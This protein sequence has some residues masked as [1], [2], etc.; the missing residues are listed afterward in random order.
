M[1][2]W[3]QN[4]VLVIGAGEL[5]SAVLQQ[6]A[7]HSLAKAN[8]N[9]V[10]VLLRGSTIESEEGQKRTKI[11]HLQK[12]GIELVPGD[13]DK[14]TITEL[15]T[16]FENFTTIVGCTGMTGGEG[17]QS[18]ILEA[19]LAAKASRYI[20]WQFGVDYDI[21]G[22][23]AGNGLFAEQCQIRQ[24]LRSQTETDWKIISTGMFMSFIFEAYFGVVT[25]KSD[26]GQIQV[27]ALG[28]W[29][30][31]VTLTHVEDIGKCTAEVV[32]RWHE[33]EDSVVFTAGDTISYQQLRN[34]VENATHE[35]AMGSE[36][37]LQSL[38][39]GLAQ[40]PVNG[41]K[42]YRLVFGESKGVAWPK[43]KSFN[44]KHAISTL[45]LGQGIQRY[46]RA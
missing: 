5:G 2:N 9:S 40:E 30:N 22:P 25:K 37:S 32:W 41:I 14:Q 24:S 38:Q 11:Q 33:V 1:S 43:E 13:I 12:L 17:T 18:K 27:N 45:T 15:A 4:K 10:S 19:V 29:S 44:F 8:G 7:E 46:L 28:N 26:T 31:K 23:E 6:L 20:P 34:E 16:T 3:N 36:L 42:K 21:I 35:D 39:Q